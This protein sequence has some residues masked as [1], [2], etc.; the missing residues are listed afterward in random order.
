[1]L[2]ADMIR[3]AS[4]GG[5]STQPAPEA[6]RHPT[7]EINP[8]AAMAGAV[9]A[10][11]PPTV[12][13]SR[14]RAREPAR[15]KAKR[16]TETKSRTRV[17]EKAK[18]WAC[19]VVWTWSRVSAAAAPTAATTRAIASAANAAA[20]AP[21]CSIANS[22]A[23]SSAR[24][25]A[26]VPPSEGA[27]SA[28]AVSDSKVKVGSEVSRSRSCSRVTPTLWPRCSLA[29]FFGDAVP[30]ER[31]GDVCL[32][33]ISIRY[34]PFSNTAP[35]CGA[36]LLRIQLFRWAV[37]GLITSLPCVGGQLRTPGAN[38]SSGA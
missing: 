17:V 35:P 3:T 25:F 32:D 14:H 24:A 22:L 26:A 19:T 5:E 4:D 28:G 37:S 21:R 27:C 31:A 6:R 1:M 7:K 34:S 36:Q 20:P 33:A 16:G 10:S 18:L 15:S 11:C 13:R 8:P 2:M 23:V 38:A 12:L 9:T 30:V 29:A